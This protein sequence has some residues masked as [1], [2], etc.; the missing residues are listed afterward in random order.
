MNDGKLIIDKI[1]AEA[2]AEAK[3]IIAKG[4]EEADAVLK[5]AQTR[6]EREGEALERDAQ[7]EAAKAKAKVISASQTKASKLILEE[8]QRILSEVIAEAEKVLNTLPDAQ[9]GEV[10]GTMLAGVTKE[11]GLEIVVSDRDRERLAKVIE[12]KGFNLSAER[13]DIDGGFIAKCGEVEYNYTFE[14]IITV[15]KEEIQQIAA[16]VLF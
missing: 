15:D 2:E 9:Y 6:L 1:I 16:K 5:A 3:A 11:A 4:Q 7:A 12:E 13:R 8:K 10:I 14:S